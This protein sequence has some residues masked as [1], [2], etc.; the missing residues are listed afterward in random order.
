[1]VVKPDEPTLEALIDMPTEVWPGED[2][3]TRDVVVA[4]GGQYAKDVH[5]HRIVVASS[6]RT[7]TLMDR[8]THRGDAWKQLLEERWSTR[9]EEQGETIAYRDWLETEAGQEYFANLGDN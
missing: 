7:P 4:M 8:L 5:R 3:F 6:R 1:M 2:I 9:A